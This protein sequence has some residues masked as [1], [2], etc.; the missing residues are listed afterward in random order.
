MTMLIHRDKNMCEE[1]HIVK[2]IKKRTVF[3]NAMPVIMYKENSQVLG[4]SILT[5]S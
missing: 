3:S 2:S 4:I 5:L 1:V